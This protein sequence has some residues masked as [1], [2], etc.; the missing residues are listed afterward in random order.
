MHPNEKEIVVVVDQVGES[1]DSS[2]NPPPQEASGTGRKLKQLKSKRTV[3]SVIHN[4]K[5][6]GIRKSGGDV[7]LAI[8]IR[9][10]AKP[11]LKGRCDLSIWSNL[12]E[13]DRQCNLEQQ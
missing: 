1:S 11:R 9:K 6:G 5:A 7:N 10:A 4:D 2:P 12:M 3:P 13:R 8:L